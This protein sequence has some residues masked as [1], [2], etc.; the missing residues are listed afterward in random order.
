MPSD[1]LSGGSSGSGRPSEPSRPS[2]DHPP[3]GTRRDI[4][5]QT[6]PEETTRGERA[7]EGTVPSQKD[8]RREREPAARDA[9]G[10]PT[11]RRGQSRGMA[12][13]LLAL[14]DSWGSVMFLGAA[15]I[16]LGALVLA[17][18]GRTLAFIAVLVGVQILLYGV[19]CVAQ[20]V[21]SQDGDARRVLMA[22][23]GV[24]AL[25]V[26]VLALRDVTHTIVVL[27]TLLGLFWI[28]A[29]VVGVM[30]AFFGRAMP[31]RGL[32]VL[33]GFLSIVAGI[34]VLAYPGLSSLALA[35]IL[36]VW[37]IVFGALALAAGWQM[38]SVARGEGRARTRQ[39]V[40]HG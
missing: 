18:P 8:R 22:L 19:L 11:T 39:A 25:V 29:G 35:V 17:W 36:G 14:G 26:G 33:S 37:L 13:V 30:S 21:A 3:H 40:G 20:A 4:P 1:P 24:L 32:V 10:R 28:A 2:S 12:T 9:I 34:V 31:G 27:A 38:R 23:I 16:V 5:E 15:S 7:P 6:S